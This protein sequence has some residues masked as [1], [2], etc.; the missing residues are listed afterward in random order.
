MPAIGAELVVQV[1]TK[2]VRQAADLVAVA[3]PDLEQ[4]LTVGDPILDTLEQ[5]SGLGQRHF[6][7][8]EFLS[9]PTG[10]PPR[11]KCLAMACMP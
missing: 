9:R 11:R 4:A 6:G 3:H 1:V 5:P 2:P 7:I 10:S 8:A